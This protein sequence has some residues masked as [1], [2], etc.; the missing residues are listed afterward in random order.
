M[1]DAY[2]EIHGTIEENSEYFL[3]SYGNLGRQLET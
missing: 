3:N 2:T 1:T